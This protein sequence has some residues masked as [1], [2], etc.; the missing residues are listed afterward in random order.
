MS[1]NI[2]SVPSLF[3]IAQ[4]LF[5]FAIPISASHLLNI[6]TSFISM[7]MLACLGQIPLAAS[8]LAVTTFITITVMIGAIFD[9][10]SI[11]ISHQNQNKTQEAAIMIKHGFV[12]ALILS[13]PE[14]LVFWNIDGLLLYCGQDPQLVELCTPYFQ[15]AAISV[16]PSLFTAVIMQYFFG[17][18][19]SQYTLWITLLCIPFTLLTSYGFIL[20]HFG[21]PGLGLAGMTCAN[22]VVQSTLLCCLMLWFYRYRHQY[23]LFT[24]HSWFKWSTCKA[25]LALGLPMGVQFGGEIAAI[26]AAT[27]L[28]GYFGTTPLAANQ[29]V[30]QYFMIMLMLILGLNQA[31]A[32]LIS[33]AY[34]KKE[35]HHI[36]KYLTAAVFI[37]SL[38]CLVSAVLF[39]GFPDLLISIYMGHQ[40]I[41][42]SFHDLAKIFFTLSVIYLII[43]GIR[44]LLS[45]ALRGM[46]QSKAPMRIGI[47]SLWLIS[48]PVS[49]LVGFVWHQGPIGLRIG[50]MSGYLVACILL[51]FQTQKS[52]GILKHESTTPCSPT[53][54]TLLPS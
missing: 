37:L 51:W 33:E 28:L 46:H 17:I 53:V 24:G 4:K 13:I 52:L 21:L 54:E 26:T 39:C 31:Q 36:S 34:G 35:L 40:W 19:K 47:F 6:I 7:K 5:R 12:L 8:A 16:F 23:P 45:G 38:Y 14:A 29:L 18:G 48:T 41:D 49:Y 15:F 20:G 11:L 32:I 22:L 44:I 2:T 3:Q 1:K 25:I 27:W 10:I 43:D 9:A 42:P 50:F 30:S